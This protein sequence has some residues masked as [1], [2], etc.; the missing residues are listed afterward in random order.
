VLGS[1]DWS[2][3]VQPAAGLPETLPGHEHEGLQQ[4]QKR[5]VKPAVPV[6]GGVQAPP[7]LLELDPP[8]LLDEDN[9]PELEDDAPELDDEDEWPPE[10][11]ELAEAS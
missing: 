1:I 10:L 4:S 3:W 5:V 2:C 6:V 8:E 11:D 7:L 9:P